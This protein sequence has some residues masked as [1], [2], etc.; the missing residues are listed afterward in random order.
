[1]RTKRIGEIE[2][3]RFVFSLIV[4]LRHGERAF[5][6]RE[7]VPF[8]GGAFAVE[9]FFIVSG[10][11]LMASIEKKQRQNCTD[12]IGAE[13]LDFIKRKIASFFPEFII[14]GTIGFFVICNTMQ[15]SL[16]ESFRFLSKVFSE[17]FLL[18]SFGFG[19]AHVNNATWYLSTLVICLTIMYPLIRK[20]KDTMVKI[21]LPLTC[22]FLLGY[23]YKICGHLRGPAEFMS[24]TYKGNI[25]GLAEVGLGVLLYPV[26][27]RIAKLELT[28]LAK[29]GISLVKWLCYFVCIRYMTLNEWD[30]RD[31]YYLFV[32]TIGIGLSFSGQGIDAEWF[33]AKVFAWAG[34]ASLPLYLSHSFYA[35]NALKIYPS[36]FS[37]TQNAA[38]YLL[39]T[40]ATAVVVWGLAYLYRKYRGY[41]KKGISFLFLK[42][43]GD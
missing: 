4:V 11:L 28:N 1:M 30:W 35:Y 5:G 38:L 14:A 31:F 2:F 9:F 6:G 43:D 40:A 15:Y 29:C 41:I 32:L 17:F 10:Y 20:Y 22:L 19:K 24:F 37:D 12:T 23:L 27:Q 39:L 21:V 25:R 3:L 18:E 26:V 7:N 36:T 16:D 42:K 8:P 34:K 13:T 33:G